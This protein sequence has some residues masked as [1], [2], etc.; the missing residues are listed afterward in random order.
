M[1]SLADTI[2]SRRRNSKIIF[3]PPSWEI[4]KLVI[5]SK[6]GW[7]QTKFEPPSR[8][9]SGEEAIAKLSESVVSTEVPAAMEPDRPE[10]LT[11]A[12]KIRELLESLPFSGAS[13]TLRQA[14]DA[15]AAQVLKAEDGSIGP[16]VPPGV[17]Q[18]LVQML[19]S[20]EIMNGDEE[21]LGKE[22]AEQQS[23]WSILSKMRRKGK[24]K[25]VDGV[26]QS[27]ASTGHAED[28]LMVY[29]PLEPLDDPQVELAESVS[30]A[31]ASSAPSSPVPVQ[32]SEDVEWMPS[33]TQM[34]VYTTWWGYR[35]YLPPAAMASLDSVSLKA[36]AQAAMVTSALKGLLNKV[37]KMLVPAQFRP[38]LAMMQRLGPVVGFIGV[39]I[40]WSW[41]RIKSH[42][43]GKWLSVDTIYF[44]H[45]TIH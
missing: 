41:S 28:G 3:P 40:A 13:A 33:T 25:D 5:D 36:A 38:A 8:T 11:F 18:D 12:Q 37:P 14:A 23:V 19:S 15:P 27:S 42:D 21:E 10:P 22:K 30:I 6:N 45:A 31:D 1:K 20:E 7:N 4:D 26:Q 9:P 32:S 44:A 17:D 2:T 29:T 35:L 34:S 39:F 43:K 24:E 16:P